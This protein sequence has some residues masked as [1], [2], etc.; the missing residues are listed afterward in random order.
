MSVSAAGLSRGG[1]WSLLTGNFAIGCGVMVVPGSL[2]SL[3]RSLDISVA[4]A[5][6]LITAAALAMCLGA[7]LL[8]ALLGGVDRRRLLTLALLWYALGHAASA[9]APDFGALLPLR[10]AC[11][12]A[13]AVFTPQAA[14]A[15][16]WLSDPSRR[17]RDIAFIFLGWSLASVLGMPLHSY[18]GETLGWRYAFGLV[19]VLSLGG[20]LWLWNALP[21]QVRPPGL[22]LRDW[23]Q[24]LTHPVW[25]GIVAVTA[26]SGAGQ[27]SLF[28]YMAPIYRE[29][30][31][32]DAATISL[33]F[34]WFGALGLVGNLYLGRRLDRMGPP[35]VVATTL[36]GMLL[37]VL[38]W[39]WAGSTVTMMLVLAPWAFSGFATNSS[40][41][42]RLTQ[43]APHR[44]SALLALNTSAIY[45]G[46][47]IGAGS[48]GLLVAANLQAGR[49]FHAG[50]S[51]AASAWLLLALLL[52]LWAARRQRRDPP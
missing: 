23:A 13:A 10:A 25:M 41:Q 16:G 45:L 9:L 22:A 26:L 30:L 4:L 28:T 52:S 1:R 29:V 14:A 7:P 40:Q 24:V 31:Q 51:W 17:G 18:I 43:V 2:N 38:A 11:M 32:A 27:F 19:A 44:A 12:L 5:G 36:C 50:L 15:V 8:A 39:P 6:Q 33:L 47:A 21:D 34:A 20:A 49:P 46:Q 48:G 3:T 35:R 37:A 42:A